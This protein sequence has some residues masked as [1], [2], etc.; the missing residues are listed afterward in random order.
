MNAQLELTDSTASD[1]KKYYGEKLE[2]GLIFQDYI[3]RELYLRGIVI[4]GF[5][6]KKYQIKHGENMLGAEIKRD[7]NFRTTGNLY[8]EIA[9]KACPTRANFTDSGI[10]RDDNSWL[11][12]IGDEK[13]VWV[14]PT[15]YLRKLKDAKK[16]EWR[17]V[18]I[19]TSKAMLMPISEADKYC[20][21]KIEMGSE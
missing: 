13:T 16:N 21:R 3:A 10:M 1:Y 19:A 17:F 15:N 4:V 2:Q 14:F 11:F 9:E 18:E 20:I 6:S 7:G 12:V 5:A 8:I